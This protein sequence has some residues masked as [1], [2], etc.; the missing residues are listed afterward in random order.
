MKFCGLRHV[1]LSSLDQPIVPQNGIVRIRI[2]A[3]RTATQY[4]ARILKHRN[5]K[6]QVIDMTGSHFEVC[7]QLRE[8]FRDETK[9]KNSVDGTK[10]DI[11]NI[12]ARRTTDNLFERVRV[13]SIHETDHQVR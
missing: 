10:V 9:R 12:Y 5:E 1:I 11:G 6:N 7:A 4:Y 3:V 2:T 8:H 13:E